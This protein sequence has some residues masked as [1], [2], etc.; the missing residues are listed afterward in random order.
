MAQIPTSQGAVKISEVQTD[1]AQNTFGTLD[2]EDGITLVTQIRNVCAALLRKSSFLL[3]SDGIVVWDGT[4]ITNN[5]NNVFLKFNQNPTV[6]TVTVTIPTSVLAG[7]TL[8]NEQVLLFKCSRADLAASFTATALNLEVSSEGSFPA[9]NSVQSDSANDPTLYV[10]LLARYDV[11]ANQ[12]VW[13]VPHGIYWPQNTGSVVGSIISATTTPVGAIEAWHRFGLAI[14]LGSP[15]L[16]TLNPGW[17]L[18]NGCVI[19]NTSSAF[20][21]PGRNADGFPNSSYSSANDFFTPMLNGQLQAF[22]NGTV[23][24]RGDLARNNSDTAAW[25]AL[26]MFTGA[27][28]VAGNDINAALPSAWSS[29]TAYTAGQYVIYTKT[30]INSSGQQMTATYLAINNVGPSATDPFDDTTNWQPIWSTDLTQNGSPFRRSNVNTDP[31]TGLNPSTMLQGK[32]SSPASSTGYSNSNTNPHTHGMS[33]THT[34][35][36]VRA[37]VNMFLGVG[38]F[39]RQSAH[40]VWTATAVASGFAAGGSSANINGGAE[41]I[42][43][44]DGPSTGNTGGAS[45]TNNVPRVFGVAYLVKIY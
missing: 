30:N 43:V 20:S 5:G 33:H 24:N 15:V 3:T 28:G 1:V 32:T 25:A 22:S 27:S 34:L 13:W 29:G 17:N 39:F 42:G 14:P 11:G 4:K 26:S 16:E 35:T 23:Y 44:S 19:I 40:T 10:P 6:G 36:Q 45:D 41:L 12:S 8:S 9:A 38:L 2:R 18:C 31:N 7:F 37:A 21:N